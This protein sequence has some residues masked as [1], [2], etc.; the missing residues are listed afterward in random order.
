MNLSGGPT[1]PPILQSQQQNI[2][3]GQQ[4]IQNPF[5]PKQIFQRQ[6]I[7]VQPPRKIMGQIDVIG[8]NDHTSRRMD[9]NMHE[10]NQISVVGTNPL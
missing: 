2:M 10:M 3:I 9:I 8:S 5:I 4:P 1:Q 6:P 7:L